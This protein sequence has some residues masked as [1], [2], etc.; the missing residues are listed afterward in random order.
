MMKART[1]LGPRLHPRCKELSSCGEK[2][3]KHCNVIIEY[4]H[5]HSVEK[6]IIS[7]V[8]MLPLNTIIITIIKRIIKIII[9]SELSK[10]ANLRDIISIVYACYH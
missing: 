6:K 3:Y 7:N 4:N 9:T 1:N 2:D 8:Y 10:K 5:Y